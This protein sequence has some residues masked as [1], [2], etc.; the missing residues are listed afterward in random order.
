MRCLPPS[1]FPLPNTHVQWYALVLLPVA[2]VLAL[3]VIYITLRLRSKQIHA[4]PTGVVFA[5]PCL[6]EPAIVIAE[7]IARGQ[8]TSVDVTK[9][10]IEQVRWCAA[11]RVAGLL[12]GR[13]HQGASCAR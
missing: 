13:W 2:A 12:G 1:L 7:K 9:A 5:H 8:Y 3:V 6:N 4:H 10:F 11:P